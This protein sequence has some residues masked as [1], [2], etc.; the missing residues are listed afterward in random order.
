M[1]YG[2]APLTP[3]LPV[4]SEVADSEIFAAYTYAALQDQA[5]PSGS[6][7]TLGLSPVGQRTGPYNLPT[8]V[9]AARHGADYMGGYI[10]AVM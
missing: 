2:H 3:C 7:A 6:H 1:T 5:Q 4:T 10:A 9:L 8:P